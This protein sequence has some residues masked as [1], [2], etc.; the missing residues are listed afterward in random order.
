MNLRRFFK[1]RGQ[2]FISGRKV[3]KMTVRLQ[4]IWRR[5]DNNG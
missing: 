5:E 2:E 3:M 4:R 1:D